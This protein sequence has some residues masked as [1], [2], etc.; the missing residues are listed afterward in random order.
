VTAS[1]A[2]DTSGPSTSAGP[3]R[4]ARRLTVAAMAAVAYVP[5]LL[6]A[7]GWIAADTKAYLYLDPSRLMERAGL[8]WNTHIDTGTVTHQNIGYLFP[9]GPYY[10]LMDTLGVPTWVAQRIW[11]GTILFAAGAGTMWML[12]RLGVRGAAVAVGGFAYMLSP[13]LLAYMGRTSVI[14]LPW[15]ALP[16]LI[17]LTRQALLERTWRAPA[18]IAVVVTL[19]AGTNASSVIYVLIGPALLVPFMIWGTREATPRQAGGAL[20][21]TAATTIPA[22]LW[23]VAG[24]WVQGKFGLPILQLTESLDTIAQTSTSGEIFRGLGYWYF[25]GRDG[26]SQWT[27]TSMLY[28]QNPGMLVVAFVLPTLGLLSAVVTRW[29]YRT[30][31]LG[32][33]VVGLVLGIGTYPFDDP[34]PFGALVKAISGTAAGFALR[35]SPRAVPLLV[36]GLAA[37][38]ATGVEAL[39][40]RVATSRRYA[41]TGATGRIGRPAWLGPVAAVGLILVALLA[42]PPLWKGQLVSND[43]RYPNE[44][45]SYWQEAAA[46]LDAKGSDTRVL[47][48]PG[49]DF[50]AYRWGQTQDPLTPGIIDRPWIGRELTAYGTPASTD[51]LRALDRRFQEGVGDPAS[52]A[53]VA[54]LLSASDLLLRMDSQYE[55]YRGPRPADLWNLFHTAGADGLGTPLIFGDPT[56]AVADPRQPTIDEQELARPTDADTAPPLAIFP[57][58]GVRPI[59]RAESTSGSLVMWGDGE[60]VVDAAE[61]GLLTGDRA[62]FYADTLLAHPTAADTVNGGSPSFVVTDTNRRRAQRWGTTRENYGA[63]EAAGSVPLVKDTKD[64]RLDV[65]PGVTDDQLSVAEYGPDV[66]DVRASSYG[67]IVAYSPE[68][69]P[70]NA[71]DG[72]LRTAWSTGGYSEVVGDRLR[73]DLTHPVTADHV[74]LAQLR[75]NRFITKVTVV[76]DGHDTV[77][78]DL[79]D[80]SFT[81][82]GQRLD[83]GGE[84]TF[85]SLEVRIDAA[86]VSGLQTFLGLSNVGIRELTIPGVTATEWIRVPA[87]G[88]GAWTGPTTPLTYLFSRSRAYPVEGFR[89]DPELS[90]RRIF[91]TPEARG[92]DLTGQ[93]RLSGRADGAVIDQLV[94]RP[95]LDAGYPIVTGDDYLSGALVDRPSSLLDGDPSTAWTLPFG[96]PVGRHATVQAP[97]P[98]TVDHLD[99]QLVADGRHSVPTS[100]VLTL[101]DGSTRT[102]AVPEIA[103]ST[104][105]GATTEVTVPVE[106]FTSATIQVAVGSVRGVSTKEY[107]SGNDHL[108]PVA[109]AELGLPVTV[110]PLPTTVPTTC[111]TGVMALDGTDVPVRLEGTVADALARQP[112]A[113]TPCAAGTVAL[114]AGD[115]TLAGL[116]GLDTGIDLDRVQLGSDPAGTVGTAGPDAADGTYVTSGKTAAGTDP[117][118]ATTTAAPV[119][120]LTVDQ[121]GDLSYSVEVDGATDP[122]WLVLGQSLS[123]GWT[124]TVD[125]GPDLGEPVLIDGFANGWHVDPAAIGD[126][127]GTFTV[128]LRWTP[129][130]VVWAAVAV[131]GAWFAAVLALL[132]ASTLRRRRRRAAT[133]DERDLAHDSVDGAAAGPTAALPWHPSPL[134]TTGARIGAAVGLGL[135]G[136]LIGGP[137]VGLVVA[138]LTAAAAWWSRGRALLLAVPAALIGGTVLVY[139]ALQVRRHYLPGVEWPGGFAATHQ[140]VLIAVLSVV[141][142]SVLRFLAHRWPAAAHSASDASQMSDGSAVT[143]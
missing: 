99:L 61:S 115:H 30:F 33:V 26:L 100:L 108:M 5:L 28:T 96:D 8:M 74:D 68:A 23:W 69:R 40:A 141:A 78:V 95:G 4:L 139:V 104:T 29:R 36:L 113:V 97:A 123:P 48:L 52:V 57:I 79:T 75:G 101:A 135:L 121:T 65:F 106:P 10:W 140:L 71:I 111:R 34:S 46:T 133:A 90:L 25:Y 14:L 91:T 142:E 17:G 81:D 3:T 93:A 102:V 58:D 53:P 66:A 42:L 18:W 56:V 109:I 125:G 76:L 70:V 137:L 117:G 21:R 83:L 50:A 41:D 114:T 77:T 119:P 129:Q 45:P 143:R 63:T 11:M 112:L 44:L 60:G 92:F 105:P 15:A 132:L 124:A 62:L 73:V 20:L 27:G 55:R 138:V 107:F 7:R 43:L 47:E 51:L 49:S 32:L 24:L 122:F 82:A 89:Q 64:T 87:A 116:P 72:D 84:H 19:M 38:L 67:N 80:P 134:A 39:T 35:N 22:Q 54:R 88:L 94:G 131:S 86:N 98:V 127:G 2:P 13:Y 12:R 126:G 16:W 59:V 85:S 118:G 31:F 130:R 110:G 6:T 136:L 9:L 128:T 1:V 120:E 103:D 37:L